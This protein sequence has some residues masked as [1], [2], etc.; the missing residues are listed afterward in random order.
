M[1]WLGTEPGT[2]A[3]EAEGAPPFDYP[4]RHPTSWLRALCTWRRPQA[5]AFTPLPPHP[6]VPPRLPP[7]RAQESTVVPVLM[8]GLQALCKERPDN[9]VEFLAHYLLQHNPQKP[10]TAADPAGEQGDAAGSGAPA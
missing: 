9:P 8:Q 4:C 1:P 6:W 10:G 7:P 5:T 3:P 2:G